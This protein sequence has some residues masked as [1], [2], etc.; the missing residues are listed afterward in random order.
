MLISYFCCNFAVVIELERHIEILLLNNECVIVPDLGGFMTHHVDAR[1]DKEEGVFLPPLR[2]LGF[3]PQLKINDSLLAQSYVEA[4]DISYPE[5]LQ[6]IEDEVNELK[7]HLQ[8]DGSYEMNDIGTLAFN[9]DGH[10]VFTPCEAGILTPSLYGLGAYEM[11]CLQIA[12]SG[13]RNIIKKVQEEPTESTQIISMTPAEEDDDDEDVVK[14]KFSWIRNTVAVAAVLIA[15]FLLALPSGKTEMMTRTISNIN[16]GLLF[17]MMSKDTNT[18]P[19]DYKKKDIQQAMVK[20]DTI[21]KNDTLS[22]AKVATK[23]KGHKGF[24]IVLASHVSK[25][26][27]NAFVEELQKKGYA[28]SEVYI[29]N[30]VTRVVYGNFETQ[31]EAYDTLRKVHRI[32]G[33]EEAWVY[34]FKEKK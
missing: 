25:K 33:L 17:G 2:T 1:Y 11:D 9:E 26:N 13:D 12:A 15:V 24:C 16:N 20:T 10:Y 8:N 29:H 32:K 3:N 5:A 34:Q 27:A 6:R 19:I 31:S 28:K 14:I 22:P 30:N 21:L 23:E 18:T 7:M 4:Y